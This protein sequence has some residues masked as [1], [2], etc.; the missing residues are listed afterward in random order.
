MRR[1]SRPSGGFLGSLPECRLVG[2]DQEMARI[3]S[4]LDSVEEGAGHL[5]LLSGEPASGKTRLLQ[6]LTLQAR[7]R[8]FVVLT[9]S[10]APAELN[11]PYHPLL[12]AFDPSASSIPISADPS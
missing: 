4:I 11:S 1:L 5:V 10:C 6:E 12:E 2:R 3:V 9:G 8:G 7:E